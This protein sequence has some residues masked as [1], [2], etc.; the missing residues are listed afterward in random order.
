[1]IDRLIEENYL[2]IRSGEKE[3]WLFYITDN[4]IIH[5]LFL[6]LSKGPLGGKFLGLVIG[7]EIRFRH[8]ISIIG[9]LRN[10]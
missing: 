10:L 5:R 7:A 2:V 3:N 6:R 1:M 4:E 8:F 9:I